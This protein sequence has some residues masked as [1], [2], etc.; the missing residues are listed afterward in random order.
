MKENSCYDMME[1]QTIYRQLISLYQLCSHMPQNP[2]TFLNLYL[3][4]RLHPM[5]RGVINNIINKHRN[6]LQNGEIVGDEET[7]GKYE[8]QE[9]DA[10]YYGLL[11]VDQTV[12]TIFKNNEQ[13]AVTP[14]DVNC[15]LNFIK[16]NSGQLRKLQPCFEELCLP[17]MT[18]EYK[19]PVFFKY[20]EAK[21]KG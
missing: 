10:Y 16:T 11:F 3:P 7:Q 8:D 15:I 19:L 5:T 21:L 9:A 13:I 2:S 14:A 20:N 1:D 6:A 4:L 12:V 18:E 17:G